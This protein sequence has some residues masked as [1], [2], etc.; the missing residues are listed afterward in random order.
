MNHINFHRKHIQ[1]GHQCNPSFS[2]ADYYHDHFDPFR[3]RKIYEKFFK[4]AN[5]PM[6][7]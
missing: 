3:K 7:K 1:L 6:P 5:I 4:D 2:Y